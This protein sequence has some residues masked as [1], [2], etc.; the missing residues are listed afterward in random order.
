MEKL[1]LKRIE[2]RIEN[3][4][5]IFLSFNLYAELLIIFSKIIRIDALLS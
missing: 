3:R 1:I 2:K 5:L 4:C